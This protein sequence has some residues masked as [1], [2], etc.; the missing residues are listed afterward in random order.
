MIVAAYVE[1]PLGAR[2]LLA[3]SVEKVAASPCRRQ[4]R[5]LSERG[6]RQHDGTV[7]GRTGAPV[8][9]VQSGR[10]C[11]IPT[12]PAQHRPVPGSQ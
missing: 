9:L 8:L 11:P 5:T 12:P 4:N 3:D 1:E 7:T 10:A 2:P 6:G